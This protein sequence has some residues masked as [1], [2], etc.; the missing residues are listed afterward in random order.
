VTPVAQGD[1]LWT[2]SRDRVEGSRMAAFLRD[3]REGGR[4]FGSYDDLWRWSVTDVEDFWSEAARL[5]GVTFSTPPERVL[6][7]RR[8]PGSEWFPGAR[9][10]YAEHALRR[11]GSG[12]AILARSESGG[13]R[14]LT[15]DEL[16]SEV[17][18]VAAALAELGVG[19]GDRVAAFLPNVP[20][21][22]IAFLATASLGAV[23]SS[24]SP[25]FGAP[26]VLDRFR[27]IEPK[28]LFA[29]TSSRYGGKTHDRRAELAAIR[30][31]L[32][33]LRATVLVGDGE[34]EGS[35][36][37]AGSAD[38]ALSWSALRGSWPLS[39]EQVS[40]S[41]PLWILYSSGTTGL[42]KPIV[43]GHGGILLEHLKAIA[44][45]GD[46]GEGD[47][48][49]WFTTTGWMMWN[50]LVS[51]LL[52]GATIQLWDGSPV[53]PD[54][55]ALWRWADE[56]AMTC[57]GTSAPYLLNCLK[58]G[59]S[60]TAT[61]PLRALKHVGSTGA[62]LPPEGFGWVYE[63]VKSDVLLGSMSGGTD[64]C[65]AFVLSCPLLPVHAGELQCRGLGAKVEAFDESGRS[66]I[67]RVGELVITEPLPSMPLFFWDDADGARLRESY[68][69]TYPGVWRHG[70]WIEITERG[71]CIITGRSDSTLNRGGVRMGTSE[72]YR[73]VEAIPE[74]ADSLVVDT[75][76]LGHE[77]KLW[78]FVVVRSGSSLDDALIARI[79]SSIRSQLSPRHVPDEI[80]AVPAIPRTLNGKKLEI[81]VKK[82][83]LG[84]PVE[85]AANPD[86]LQDPKSLQAFVG[87]ASKA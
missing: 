29:V 77:D 12:L 54:P 35:A 23:W 27:Q 73:V 33:S 78:L 3:L 26:S 17:A 32:P 15:R 21:A 79:K 52:V 5:L 67:G 51:G 41:H 10:N 14:S 87:W 43:Q 72:F 71:T 66:V 59:L 25:D 34:R 18:R 85:Q 8:M 62:P 6:S 60:P 47:R 44:L 83:L 16:R 45:H 64:A 48:F 81:P 28:V 69:A 53:H 49:F 36:D 13:E 86:T 56:S 30:A 46:L 42:P 57:F 37:A 70:D 20:E 24:C 84:A 63:H 19:P 9:L 7:S 65:T 74:I 50:F 58:L 82:I 75:G 40:F 4:D 80:R 61:L 76:S 68:F 38:G 22:V 31:G 1:L 11:T 55:L 2:P 39:F